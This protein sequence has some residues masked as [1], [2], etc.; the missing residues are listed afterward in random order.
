MTNNI[1]MV[2]AVNAEFI[3]DI[4]L[5]PALMSTVQTECTTGILFKQYPAM[6]LSSSLLTHGLGS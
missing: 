5:S 3:N 2:T 4:L 1:K 6:S